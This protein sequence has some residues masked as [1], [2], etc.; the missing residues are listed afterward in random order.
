MPVTRSVSTAGAATV[1]SEAR[2]RAHS[3]A[4]P[5]AV[6]RRRLRRLA[7]SRPSAANSPRAPTMCRNTAMAYSDIGS[8]MG[9]RRLDRRSLRGR[10]PIIFI[11][12]VRTININ[13]SMSPRPYR[14]GGRQGAIEK[15]R[16]RV[17]RAAR[18][19]L[20]VRGGADRFSIDAVARRAGVARMTVYH[21]FGSRRGLLEALFDSFAVGRGLPALRVGALP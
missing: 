8:S 13:G 5:A 1:R 9:H 20:A 14:L 19:L 16:K 18:D 3:L 4:W 17:L 21:Q 10:R 7:H 2:T 15:T 6:A 11:Y 12:T